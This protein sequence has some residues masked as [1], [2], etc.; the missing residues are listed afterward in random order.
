MSSSLPF[1]EQ[2]AWTETKT[3]Q[4]EH[5]NV[6]P[7]RKGIIDAAVLKLMSLDIDEDAAQQSASIMQSS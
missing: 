3:A 7:S 1:Q 5:G 4:L 2:P 6:V